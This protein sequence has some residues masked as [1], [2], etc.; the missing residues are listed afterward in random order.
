MEKGI[1]RSGCISYKDAL[2]Q[3]EDVSALVIE[4]DIPEQRK[5]NVLALPS[6]KKV[7]AKVDDDIVRVLEKCCVGTTI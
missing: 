4:E 6:L 2:L 1:G 7:V 5:W 3:K